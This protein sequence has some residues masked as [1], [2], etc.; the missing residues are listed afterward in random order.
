[1]PRQCQGFE[2]MSRSEQIT[3][4]RERDAR[5][6]LG[7]AGG[8]IEGE[9]RCLISKA[10]RCASARSARQSEIDLARAGTKFQMPCC[11]LL[12]QISRGV[13]CQS[14][15][16]NKKIRQHRETRFCTGPRRLRPGA[17]NAHG[18]QEPATLQKN[19]IRVAYGAWPDNTAEFEFGPSRCLMT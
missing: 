12:R 4:D 6:Q 17:G 8:R 5:R 2:R 18:A 7:S 13:R 1:M 15:I 10:R 11:Q 19:V 3:W 16:L 14:I 9:F